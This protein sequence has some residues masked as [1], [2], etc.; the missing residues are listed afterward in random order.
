MKALKNFF[1]V[2][3]MIVSSI[4]FVSCSDNDDDEPQSPYASTIIGTWKITHYGSQSNWLT[5]PKSTTTATFNSDGTYSG[6]GYFG[7]GTGTYTLKNSHITCY[8]DGEVY[9]QYDIISVE[10]GIAV[11]D[12]YAGSDTSSKITI[13]CKKI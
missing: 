2:M 7:T 12:M 6:R 3:L 4:S 11:L 9:A 8:V 10:N 1:F 13:K 5:W